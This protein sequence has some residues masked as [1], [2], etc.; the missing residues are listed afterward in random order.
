[1]RSNEES[2]SATNNNNI[3]AQ[4][5]NSAQLLEGG[6]RFRTAIIALAAINLAAA[7]MV[8]GNILYDTWAVRN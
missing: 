2:F 6:P 1:M 8:M 3:L 7:I 4:Q 5:V